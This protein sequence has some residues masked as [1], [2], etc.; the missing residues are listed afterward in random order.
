[1]LSKEEQSPNMSSLP[2]VAF[3]NPNSSNVLIDLFAWNH[4]LVM[5][6]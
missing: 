2:N 3:I 5:E 4:A 1:M 6:I